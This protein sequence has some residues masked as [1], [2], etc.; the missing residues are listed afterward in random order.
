MWS[1]SL[2]HLMVAFCS[3]CMEEL[4][5]A[6][7]HPV[8]CQPFPAGLY[9]PCVA[10]S[11]LGDGFAQIFFSIIIFPLPKTPNCQLCL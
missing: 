2:Y 3:Q 9:K 6:Q 10:L 4:S 1:L 11:G 8:L 7:G 5:W